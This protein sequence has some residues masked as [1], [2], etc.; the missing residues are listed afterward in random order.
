MGG[1]TKTSM[2]RA[3]W[4]MFIVAKGFHTLGESFSLSKV[5]ESE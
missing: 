5:I 1:P 4:C 2:N 3:D